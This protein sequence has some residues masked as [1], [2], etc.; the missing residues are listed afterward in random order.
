MVESKTTETVNGKKMNVV[1]SFFTCTCG[2][3]PS[4][5]RH[6]TTPPAIKFEQT[7]PEITKPKTMTIKYQT[8]NPK[9]KRKVK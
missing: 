8:T 6:G 7:K 2:K 3:M 9:N 1:N 5:F 4:C